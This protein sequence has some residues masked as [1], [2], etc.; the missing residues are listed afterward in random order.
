MKIPNV[1]HHIAVAFH[2]ENLREGA[3]RGSLF[4]ETAL[5]TNYAVCLRKTDGSPVIRLGDGWPADLS[6]DGKWALAVV[7]SRPPELVIYP[8]GAGETRRL[9]RGEIENYA[10]AQWFR[11]GNRVLICGNEPG[12][13]TRA[14]RSRG[15]PVHARDR[16]HG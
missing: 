4:V 6:A 9:E 16:R 8:T 5:G 13:G 11:D 2:P 7:Q 12:K 10:T 3:E 1:G 15:T 14:R